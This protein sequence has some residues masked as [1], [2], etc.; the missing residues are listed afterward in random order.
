MKEEYS[1]SNLKLSVLDGVGLYNGESAVD[2][3][4]HSTEAAQLIDRLGYTRVWFTEHHNSKHQM[5]TSPDLLIAHIAAMTKS[6]RVGSGGI[7][8]PNHSALR[9]V[10][11]FSI[12]E[13]LHPGR[14][15]L[16]MGRASG[17]NAITNAALR[18]SREPLRGEAVMNQLMEVLA[19]FNREFPEGHPYQSISPSPD[20]SLRPDL[21]MLGSSDGGMQIAAQLGMGFAFAGQ[22]NPT[23][24]VPMLRKYRE[25][26]QPSRYFSKPYSI[27]SVIIICAPTDE[28]AEYLA[29]PAILQWARWGT[30]QIHHAPPTLEEAETHEYTIEEQQAVKEGEGRFIIGSPERV[31]SKLQ[32]L[33]M[34]AQADEIM[35]VNMITDHQAQLQS[36]KLLADIFNL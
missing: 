2:A 31:K 35:A 26:F 11:N 34:E 14:I 25:H 12:L 24:A 7:M 32:A 23:Y 5:S 19:F 18:N 30:G 29:A 6:I 27:L 17:T 28:E 21:Y 3:L 13:A 33:A 9:I 16:G 36:Y 15:D 8:L 4:K 10:E 22:I 1:I 20:L